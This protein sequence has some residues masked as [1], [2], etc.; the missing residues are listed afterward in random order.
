MGLIFRDDFHDDFGA[1]PIGYIPYGGADLGEV[2]AVGRAVGDG[3]DGAFYDAWVAA[4]D[5]FASQAEEA[6]AAG[7]RASARELFLRASCFYCAAYHPIYGAPVD[8][9]LVAAFR[10]QIVAFDSGLALNDPPVEPLRIPFAGGSLPGYLI[11]AVGA[12]DTARP[13][14]IC[15]NGYDATVTDM[16]FASA[17]AASRRGYHCLIFD[18]PGQGENLIEHGLHL[19]PDWETVVAAVVDFALTLPHVDANRMAL[20]GW[21]LGGHLAPRAASGEHRLAAL[22]ADPG[23]WSITGAFRAFAMKCGAT[24]EAAASL[25]TLGQEVI[26]RMWQAV[27][28]DRKLRWT[29]VQRGFWVHGVDNLRDYLRSVEEFTLDGRVEDI[30]CPTLLT[31]GENDPLATT[32]QALFEALRCQKT[33]IRFTA[34][35]GAGDHCEM[36]NR[37]LFNRH[38]LDWLD[39]VL[40]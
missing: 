1:W 28:N 11:P 15:T 5:R 18:G 13:L 16:Y 27:T 6:Q 10:K 22:I 23:L 37:S 32:A 24:E 35:Q 33:L 20:S 9:R 21:S 14:L 7:R 2:I 12:G 30:R 38:A 17:V 39:E 31:A 34:A 40:G 26:D 36:K 29:V 4:G 25:G 3:D 19:R 8:P